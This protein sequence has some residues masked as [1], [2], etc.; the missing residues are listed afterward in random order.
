MTAA[1]SA[2]V[3]PV[4]YGFDG[5]SGWQHGHVKPHDIG[6]GAGGSL[7]VRGMSWA[8][9]SQRT[10]VGHGVRW[11]DS[12]IPDCASGHYVKVRATL[13]LSGIKVHSGLRYFS[14]LTMQWKASGKTCKSVFHWRP[15]AV[16]GAPPFWN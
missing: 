1:S 16:P 7:F 4:A 12:C 13:T 6:F 2:Q 14:K 9:W 5:S 3:P 8:D 11:A 15:G 10:A